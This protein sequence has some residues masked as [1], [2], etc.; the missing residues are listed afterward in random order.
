MKKKIIIFGNSHV[1][2]IKVAHDEFKSLIPDNIIF[3]FAAIPGYNF[4]EHYNVDNKIFIPEKLM[5][6][7]GKLNNMIF[8]I[9]INNYDHI[10]W[11]ENNSPLRY[12]QD[13]NDFY[14][15]DVLE[16]YIKGFYFLDKKRSNSLMYFLKEIPQKVIFLG[17]PLR[18]K[19][20]K[21]EI[22]AKNIKLEI[23][24]NQVDLIRSI[25]REFWEKINFP[26]ILIP[27]ELLFD[28]YVF[29]KEKFLKDGLKWDGKKHNR[30]FDLIHMN[31]EYG[32][33]IL[34]DLIAKL[35]NLNKKSVEE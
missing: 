17:I 30:E 13:R 5:K 1:G 35:S 8:P 2:A 4:F 12:F 7:S 25:C 14:S 6:F 29:T 10:V 34:F 24:K 15:N 33:I 27:K 16:N 19:K 18:K 31:Q 23:L 9:D 11:V 22:I 28:D 3:D 20:N 26:S 32:K 21:D